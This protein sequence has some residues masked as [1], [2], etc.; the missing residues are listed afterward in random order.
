MDFLIRFTKPICE[1]DKELGPGVLLMRAMN[2]LAEQ[3]EAPVGAFGIVESEDQVEMT[4]MFPA[5][6]EDWKFPQLW[7][8]MGYVAEAQKI[9]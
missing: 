8:A 1:I 4:L 9:G 7:E 5:E 3:G 6:I 2:W